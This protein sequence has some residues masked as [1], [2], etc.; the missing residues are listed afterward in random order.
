MCCLV[1]V[2]LLHSLLFIFLKVLFVLFYLFCLFAK[3]WEPEKSQRE[4]E[5]PL[6]TEQGSPMQDSIPGPR[7]HDPSQGQMLNQL[8]HSG[9][10][11][12]FILK[13]NFEIWC[14]YFFRIKGLIQDPSGRFSHLEQKSALSRNLEHKCFLHARWGPFRVSGE[15]VVPR[16]PWS[17]VL[18]SLS[19]SPPTLAD[20]NF[21]NDQ[22]SGPSFIVWNLL[23][24]DLPKD[25]ST[26]I[27]F[28]P[29]AG[30]LLCPIV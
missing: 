10:P 18:G 8:S 19:A 5:K 22:S 27:W 25:H 13:Y 6:T 7:G 4:R 2:Y 3:E 1:R 12:V 29:R 23:Q 20:C 26:N 9:A 14:G 17:W 24:V 15:V 16:V 28:V 11:L 30:L 21:W